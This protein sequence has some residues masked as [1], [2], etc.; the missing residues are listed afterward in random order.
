MNRLVSPEYLKYLTFHAGTAQE[1]TPDHHPHLMLSEIMIPY[2]TVEP[3][4]TGNASVRAI[5]LRKL[6]PVVF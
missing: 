1:H 2:P 4:D 6:T 5:N 3:G